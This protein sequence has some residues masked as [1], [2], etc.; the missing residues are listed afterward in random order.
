LV[1]KLRKVTTRT[2]SSVVYVIK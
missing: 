1:F 2:I